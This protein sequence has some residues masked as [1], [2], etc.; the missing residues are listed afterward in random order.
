MKNMVRKVAWALQ[1]E[2]QTSNLLKLHKQPNQNVDLS[3]P[4]ESI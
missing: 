3:I 4:L 2:V 1:N